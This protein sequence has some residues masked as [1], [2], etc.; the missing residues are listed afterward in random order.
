MNPQAGRFLGIQGAGAPGSGHDLSYRTITTTGV[1][2]SLPRRAT[3]GP[4][5]DA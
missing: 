2:D 4:D 1:V 3:D 5:G